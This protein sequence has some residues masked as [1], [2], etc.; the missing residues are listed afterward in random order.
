[1]RTKDGG[2]QQQHGGGGVLGEDKGGGGGGGGS[3]LPH[4]DTYLRPQDL[5]S[6][7]Q[8]SPSWK[9]DSS[10]SPLHLPPLETGGVG[11]PS[12][13]AAAVAVS[14]PEVAVMSRA[15]HQYHQHHQDRLKPLAVADYQVGG[16]RAAASTACGLHDLGG[17]GGRL[18]EGLTELGVVPYGGEWRHHHVGHQEAGAQPAAAAAAARHQ[19]N[20]WSDIQ[21]GGVNRLA[22]A[23]VGGGEE[24]KAA[25]QLLEYKKD[26]KKEAAEAAAA[27]Y[28]DR[29][30]NPSSDM[31]DTRVKN[32]I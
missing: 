12:A 1:M 28:S 5:S 25:D 26:C 6:S 17:G 8:S 9:S 14:A 7:K 32:G 18:A 29:N 2:G 27:L 15:G 13:A 10:G 16:G 3:F 23:A 24:G 19:L 4:W 30:N 21:V 22:K 11:C 20:S 31:Y